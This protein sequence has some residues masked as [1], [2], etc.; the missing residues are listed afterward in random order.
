M[1]EEAVMNVVEVVKKPEVGATADAMSALLALTV[2]MKTRVS[3]PTLRTA[4]VAVVTATDSDEA[5]ML[6]KIMNDS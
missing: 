1:A 4:T 6:A 5:P 2:K 3:L